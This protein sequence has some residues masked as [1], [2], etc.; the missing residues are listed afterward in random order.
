MKLDL[1]NTRLVEERLTVDDVD[2]VATDQGLQPSDLLHVATTG[3]I[4]VVLQVERIERRV[5]G[6]LF[7]LTSKASLLQLEGALP[8]LV[9]V[10]AGALV[11]VRGVG[12]LDRVTDED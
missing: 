3:Q 8:R 10:A 11:G 12:P 6:E 2:A 4:A 7:S 9:L 5:G 1:L